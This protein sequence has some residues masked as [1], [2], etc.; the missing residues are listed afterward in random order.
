MPEPNKLEPFPAMQVEISL[1]ILNYNGASWLDRC[2]ESICQQSA[3]N[4][5]E[6]IVTDNGSS[7]GSQ[8]ICARYASRLPGLNFINHGKNLWYCQANN[9]GAAAARSPLLFILNNDL[10]LEPDCV[11]LLLQAAAKN[12]DAQAFSPRVLDYD[13]NAFQ[14]FGGLGIDWMGVG[15]VVPDHSVPRELFSAYGCAF[16]IRKDCFFKIGAYPPEML[17]YGDE[18]DLAWRLQVAG[19]RI[20][21]TPAAKVHHRGAAVANPAGGVKHVELRTNEMKRFLAVRN[22]LLVLMK[23]CQHILLLLLIPHLLMLAGEAL[24]F[25]IA[26]RNWRFVRNSYGLGVLEALRMMPHVRVWRKRIRS[27]RKRGDFWV[28]QYLTWRMNRLY[29]LMQ[30]FKLG[31][32]KIK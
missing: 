5:L 22:G 3:A 19:G 18:I 12:L 13:S 32:P 9:I 21:T 25:L 26:T 31:P 4:R 16:V 8:Q 29:E 1:I 27:F 11:E 23:N 10:W 6:V 7:D 15:T 2:L 30:I 14:G 28:L 20:L 24:F 17:I